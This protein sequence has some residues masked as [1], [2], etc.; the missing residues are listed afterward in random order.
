[1]HEHAL[2]TLYPGR[3][4]KELVGGRP[5]QDERGRL[6]GVEA[7]RHAGQVVGS[8]RAIGGVRAGTVISATRSPR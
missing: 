1:M 4:M 6:G 5:A 2:A 8:E 3:A 7:R